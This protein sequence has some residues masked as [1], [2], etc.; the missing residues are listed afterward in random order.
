[1]ASLDTLSMTGTEL[2]A[3]QLED[4]DG[5][6]VAVAVAVIFFAIG[7]YAGKNV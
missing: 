4:V 5:G 3:E 1:M 7:Y 6:L 2:T